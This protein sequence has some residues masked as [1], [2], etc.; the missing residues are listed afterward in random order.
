MGLSVLKKLF[1]GSPC[2]CTNKNKRS[3]R[4]RKSRKNY[5]GGHTYSKKSPFKKTTIRLS[6][7]K[8]NK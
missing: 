5:R 8:L 2:G 6:R 4:K 7:S 3:T 1:K